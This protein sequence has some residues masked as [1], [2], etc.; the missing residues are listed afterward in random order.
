MTKVR[1]AEHTYSGV[2]I[3][4]RYRHRYAITVR[5]AASIEIM[6]FHTRVAARKW[7]RALK[8]QGYT[9]QRRR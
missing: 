6:R 1:I 7:Q 4:D 8:Q 2:Y 5:H 3:D 9:Y